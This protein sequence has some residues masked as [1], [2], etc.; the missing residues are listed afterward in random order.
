MFTLKIMGKQMNEPPTP[1]AAD[2]RGA[3]TGAAGTS[4]G[5]LLQGA[6]LLERWSVSRSPEG[7]QLG[8]TPLSPSTRPS[9]QPVSPCAPR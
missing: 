9:L 2:E 1:Q 4:L 3:G 8:R 7:R 5:H 6:H